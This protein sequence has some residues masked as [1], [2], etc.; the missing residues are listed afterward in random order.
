MLSQ[1]KTL[2]SKNN[3]FLSKTLGTKFIKS[4]KEEKL[5]LK[6][7]L[8]GITTNPVFEK[9]QIQK[10]PNKPTK[11]IKRKI[12]NKGLPELSERAYTLSIQQS[13]VTDLNTSSIPGEKISK[14][15]INPETPTPYISAVV[16]KKLMRP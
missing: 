4:S 13:P 14:K 3:K 7:K 8:Q 1:N 9:P 11:P 16:L 2:G 10:I 12:S 5:H 6:T 15:P